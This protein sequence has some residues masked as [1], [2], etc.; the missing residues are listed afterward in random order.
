LAATVDYVGS[1]HFVYASD[2][3]HWDNEFPGNLEH[4]RNHPDL[5]DEV[6]EKILRKNAQRLFD[7]N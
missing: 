2:I 3:P 5:S 7:L 1:D 4:L 6:K